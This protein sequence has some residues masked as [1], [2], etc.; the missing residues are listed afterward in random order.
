MLAAA[1]LFAADASD[2]AKAEL[3]RERRRLATDTKTLT[4]VSRRLETALSQLATASR[5][6]TDAASRTDT[7]PDE[8]SRR[9]DAVSDSEQEVRSLLEKRR[10]VADRIVER[11]RSIALLEGEIQTRKPA[12]A[13]S[14]RW[15]VTLDP[16]SQR[17]VFRMALDG[18]IVTGEY[19]LEGGFAGSL[20]G[21]LVNDRLRLERVDSRLG[22]STVYYGRVARDATSIAG[23]WEATTFGSGAPGAGIWKAVREEE[24][25][26]SP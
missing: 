21:T 18:T 14:G 4:D 9:E 24:R 20:R 22:F 26:E 17:G 8:I 23:T 7:G 12:D 6:V 5:A 11:R 10:L 2:A 3:S 1:A 19:T 25:E 16:G 15:A 13:V